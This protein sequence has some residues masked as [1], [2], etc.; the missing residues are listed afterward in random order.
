MGQIQELLLENNVGWHAQ[1]PCNF[2]GIRVGGSEAHHHS[3]D[4]IEIGFSWRKAS[5]AA[6][7]EWPP[8]PHDSKA[9][10]VNITWV[11]LSGGYIPSSTQLKLLSVG[12]G[13]TNF[14]L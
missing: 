6:A 4:I 8:A 11:E 10:E 9:Q 7:F 5:D 2:V 14:F 13:H 12:G 3:A 1:A